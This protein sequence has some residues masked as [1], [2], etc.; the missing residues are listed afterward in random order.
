MPRYPTGKGDFIWQLWH[1][2]GGDPVRLADACVE[3]G[4]AWVAV[5]L[6]DGPNPHANTRGQLTECVAALRAVGVSVWGWGYVYGFLPAAEGRTAAELTLAYE[7]DG[8]LIDAEVEYKHKRAQTFTFCFSLRQ[9]L[10]NHPIGLCSYRFPNSHPEIA[11]DVFLDICDFHAPQVY[12]IGNISPADFGKQLQQSVDQLRLKRDLPI[13]PIGPA[14]PHPVNVPANSPQAQMFPILTHYANGTVD[15]LWSPTVVQLNNFNAAARA[16]DLPGVGWWSWQ[17]AEERPD[18]WAA[19]AAHQWQAPETE[20]P[21]FPMPKGTLYG[22]HGESGNQII[23]LIDKYRA[24]G[25]NLAVVLAV[26]NPG[27]CVDAKARGVPL[28]IARWKNPNDTYEGGGAGVHTWTTA[29]RHDFAAK[30]IQMIFDRCNDAEYAGSD[31]FTPG[32]NEWDHQEPAGWT[33]AGEV[34]CLLCDE[35]TRRNPEKT[36]QGAHP[37]RLAIPGFNN[38]TPKT[39]AMYQALAATGLFAKMKARGDLLIFHEGVW[40]DEP[41]TQGWGDVIPG[42]PVVPGAGSK[43]FRSDYL[44][45]LL[46]Q[47]GEEVLYVIGEWY[48]GNKRETPNAK[49]LAAMQWYDRELRKRPNARGFCP[50]ELTD[51]PNSTW[52]PVDFTPVFQSAEMLADMVAE[53]DKA[54]PTGVDPMSIK[55]DLQALAAQISAKIEQL[56]EDAPMPWW[57]TK[58]PPYQVKAKVE[59]LTLY[60]APAGAVDKQLNATWNIDVWERSGEWLRVTGAQPAGSPGCGCAPPMCSRPNFRF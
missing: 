4:I 46:K 30:A 41:I 33:A 15:V 13:V 2:A 19:L 6:H 51:D 57:E 7:L 43:C 10:P 55:Q 45:H 17:H 49:R 25:A 58:T 42:A 21:M 39:Y 38:G 23:P 3:A 53:K 18:W 5:K 20:A 31:F 12:P 59:P 52:R 34:L 11:W 26:E 1:C 47:R 60:K 50:F 29:M 16:L 56:P 44:M 54:N 24:H 9:H 28:T 32:L 14:C 40:W 35:A 8:Y 22:A 37:I 36:S 48:D 27:L